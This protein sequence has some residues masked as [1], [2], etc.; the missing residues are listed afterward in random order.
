MHIIQSI[1]P[2]INAN[3]CIGELPSQICCMIYANSIIR[4]TSINANAITQVVAYLRPGWGFP[5]ESKPR[6]SIT[7]IIYILYIYIIYIYYI[8][9]IYIYA[10]FNYRKPR[11]PTDCTGRPGVQTV[12]GPFWLTVPDC[13]C[14]INIWV[15][16]MC[17]AVYAN[18]VWAPFDFPGP[19]ED[20][21]PVIWASVLVP[22]Q[23]W[24][25]DVLCF[26][27]RNSNAHVGL[28][29]IEKI[30]FRKYGH[31]A[32]NLTHTLAAFL[33]YLTRTHAAVEP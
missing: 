14:Q 32:H 8:Y 19:W 2:G 4:Y 30:W 25:Y 20:Y 26:S 23:Y 17:V 9:N 5:Y 13:L 3:A 11:P 1:Y 15:T 29:A 24:S 28:W 12:P 33:G 21:A 10:L 6:A 31:R 16:M 22:T 27:L 18:I 7:S